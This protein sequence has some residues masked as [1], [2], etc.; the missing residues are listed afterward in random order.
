MKKPRLT[1]GASV[2]VQADQYLATLAGLADG[3]FELR[4]PSRR[5]SW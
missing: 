3:A 1:T 5:L 4:D 2:S